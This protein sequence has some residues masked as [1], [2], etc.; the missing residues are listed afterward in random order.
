M[1]KNGLQVWLFGGALLLG[2]IAVEP[3]AT[4]DQMVSAIEAVF[5]ITPGEFVG[6]PEAATRLIRAQSQRAGK[7]LLFGYQPLQS[8]FAIREYFYVPPHFSR[9]VDQ[10]HGSGFGNP[11]I[12]N[13]SHGLDLF[14]C[15]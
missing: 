5:G 9:G 12:G 10:R 7:S 14:D 13:D 8:F 3:E 11:I 4:V 2:G 1:R 6:R 15:G